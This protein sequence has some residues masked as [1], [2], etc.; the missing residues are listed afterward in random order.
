M[1]A[2]YSILDGFDLG[3]GAIHWMVGRT[4]E[5]RRLVLESIG[6][7]WDGNEVWLIAAGGTLYFAFPALYAASF[8]GFYLPLTIVLWII[9]LRGISIEIRSHIDDPLWHGF[10]D[11]VFTLSGVLLTLFL[12]AALGNVVRGVPLNADGYFVEPLW[13]TFRTTGRP[14][15]LDW[16]TLLVGVMTFVTLS[17]H[18]AHWLML[19]THEPLRGRARRLAASTWWLVALLTVAGFFATV[20]IRPTILVRYRAPGFGWL[21]AVVTLGALA[22]MAIFR[23]RNKDLAGFICSSVYIAGMLGGIA[24]GMYPTLLPATTGAQYSLT[25]ANSAAGAYGLRGGLVWWTASALLV[26]AYFAYVYWMFR[27]RVSAVDTTSH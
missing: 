1:L 23:R 25:V 5:E 11:F 19:K 20:W 2:M 12:G 16:Y 24:F 13:T 6:P 14:G 26:I 17:N 7:V 10:Y 9:M 21:I 22:G 8:S 18:G 3:V 4:R 15:I 27:H